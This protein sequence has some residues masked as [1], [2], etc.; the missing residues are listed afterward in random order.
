MDGPSVRGERPEWCEA[1]RQEGVDDVC[2]DGA[3]RLVLD[4]HEDLLLLLQVDEVP[5]PGLLGEPGG[6]TWGRGLVMSGYTV[7][8]AE[9][10]GT[11]LPFSPF[12]ARGQFTAL[13]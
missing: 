6:G 2:F 8:S 13:T 1:H 5:K 9:R 12:Q 10:L 4:D 3:Q 7:P 11:G